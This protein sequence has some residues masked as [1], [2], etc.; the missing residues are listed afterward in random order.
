[1]PKFVQCTHLLYDL[2]A[3]SKNEY[4]W[5]SQHRNQF[6]NLKKA[7]TSAL[8]LATLDLEADFIL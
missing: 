5:T 3:K 6:E 1:V 2:V 8:V 4:V 7:L